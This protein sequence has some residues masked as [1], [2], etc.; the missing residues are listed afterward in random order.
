MYPQLYT[1]SALGLVCRMREL[2]T[3]NVL[4][5]PVS[6]ADCSRKQHT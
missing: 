3:L 2:V 4:C 1:H 5:L 6:L